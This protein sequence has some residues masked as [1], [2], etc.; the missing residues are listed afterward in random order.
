MCP[1]PK[2]RRQDERYRSKTVCLTVL[3]TKGKGRKRDRIGSVGNHP[4]FMRF[5]AM[6][7]PMIPRPKNPTLPWNPTPPAASARQEESDK[8]YQYY[9]ESFNY[10]T[11]TAAFP[12]VC[13]NRRR[14]PTPDE[15]DDEVAEQDTRRRDPRRRG[16]VTLGLRRK[17]A[18]A[19]AADNKRDKIRATR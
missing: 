6:G 15:E 14:E 10:T 5:D 1:D 13:W 3:A 7:A 17:L 9:I 18:A 16:S 12:V 8:Y 2:T 11:Y 4:A 19:M